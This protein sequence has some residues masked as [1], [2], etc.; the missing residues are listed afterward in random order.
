MYNIT[1]NTSEETHFFPYYNFV[2]QVVSPYPVSAVKVADSITTA[3]YLISLLS[4]KESFHNLQVSFSTSIAQQ[5]TSLFVSYLAPGDIPQ[6][7]PSPSRSSPRE[8]I[9]LVP[10]FED[11]PPSPPPPSESPPT[12]KPITSQTEEPI[13]EEV[14]TSIAILLTIFAVVIATIVICLAVRQTSTRT[15]GGFS[16][17]LPKTPSQQAFPVPSPQ[18]TSMSGLTG[19][20]TPSYANQRTPPVPGMSGSGSAFRRPGFSPSPQHTLFSQ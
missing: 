15:Q 10:P 9:K 8:Q 1:N 19:Y 6:A 16:A 17:H 13:S 4:V 3:T 18:S 20:Q 2:L 12:E 11:T 5:D 14:M 7:P